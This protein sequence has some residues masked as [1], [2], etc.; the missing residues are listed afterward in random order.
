MIADE[1]C[2]A[3][4]KLSDV[5]PVCFLLL[6]MGIHGFPEFTWAKIIESFQAQ[7]EKTESPTPDLTVGWTLGRSGRM[8]YAFFPCSAGSSGVD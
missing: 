5:T 4:Y 2:R 3:P 1:D 6:P 7:V 8:P